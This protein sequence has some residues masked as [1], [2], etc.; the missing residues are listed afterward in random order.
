MALSFLQE[1]NQDI[2]H[3]L[4]SE[5]KYIDP[6]VDMDVLAAQSIQSLTKTLANITESIDEMKTTVY[7]SWLNDPKYV[8]NTVLGEAIKILLDEKKNTVRT[9]QLI[10][11]A[12][13]YTQVS[14]YGDILEGKRSIY[15]G[16]KYTGWMPFKESVAIEKAKQ[17]LRYG[18][19][20][21][22]RELYVGIAN[23]RSDALNNIS[24]DHII[25][26]SKS[27]LKEMEEYCDS[28]W[29][30]LWPWEVEAPEKLKYMIENREEKQMKR[31]EEMQRG[32]IRVLREFDE[33]NMSQFEMISASQE[34]MKRVDSMISDL[35]KLSSNGI[36]V[37]AQAKASGDESLVG[38]MQNALGDPLNTAVTALTDLKAA[39]SSATSDLT[40]GGSSMNMDNPEPDMGDD[41]GTPG[42]AMGD[43]PMGGSSDP[44]DDLDIGSD[45]EE[46]PMKEV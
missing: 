28:R 40:G 45:E 8:R 37:M 32:L 15:L 27:A 46:R 43:D 24:M 20:D 12:T 23:G 22:F 16:A 36:E 30:G 11:G 38:P 34:M 42:D 21:D 33:G 14:Q 17:L 19:K 1:T 29:N 5:L 4:K 10:P 41:L 13:Y 9:D 3:K 44:I 31:I 35:G 7:G 25:G 18:N 6:K 39:L 2:L 26:S